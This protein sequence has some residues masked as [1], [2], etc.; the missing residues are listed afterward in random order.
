MSCLLSKMDTRRRFVVTCSDCAGLEQ[1]MLKCFT[2]VWG[3]QIRLSERDMQ[4]REI[5]S[6]LA[7]QQKDI[8]Q[9]LLGRV[10]RLEKYVEML[11]RE[12][13]P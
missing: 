8:M 11:D 4:Y 1:R 6:R 2:D 3:V 12:V 7:Q 13:R 5:V 9:L 10:E